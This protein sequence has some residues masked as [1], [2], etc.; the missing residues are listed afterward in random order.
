MRVLS[1][2][3]YTRMADSRVQYIHNVFPLVD[4]R[5]TRGD[6]VQW[7]ERHG[8]P[9]PIKSACIG[10]P[11]RR[12]SEWRKL[13]PAEFADAVDFDERIRHHNATLTGQQFVHRSF[14]PLAEVDLRSEQDRGQLEFDFD[15]CG[16]LCP[17]GEVA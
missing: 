13:T 3:S 5:M 2:A 6:C 4:L 8:Y 9:E 7:L 17:A 11:Y 10:C 14:L 12:N 1:L 16:V 15:G